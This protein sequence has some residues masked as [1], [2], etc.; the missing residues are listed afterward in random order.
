MAMASGT[1]YGATDPAAAAKALREA[2]EA[3]QLHRPRPMGAPPVRK[4]PADRWGF[5]GSCA[6]AHCCIIVL[7]ASRYHINHARLID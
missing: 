7:N 2:F 3:A 4:T 1:V 6:V 5:F